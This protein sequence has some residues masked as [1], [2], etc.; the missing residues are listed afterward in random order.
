LNQPSQPLATPYFFN[1]IAPEPTFARGRRGRFAVEP[2]AY[3][4]A[5]IEHDDGRTDRS[6]DRRHVLGTAKA[7]SS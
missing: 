7:N 1:G 5:G 3:H 6:A 2:H 4:G